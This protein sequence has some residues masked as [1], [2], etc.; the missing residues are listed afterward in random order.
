MKSKVTLI[1]F[2]QVDETGTGP[3]VIVRSEP[4]RIDRGL[5]I[6]EGDRYV[7]DVLL[8]MVNEVVVNAIALPSN[9]VPTMIP[10][11]KT[12]Y[13]RVRD[14]RIVPSSGVQIPRPRA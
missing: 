8:R 7:S 14:D 12:T 10:T 3:P 11:M 6:E 9:I 4:D 13:I 2:A 5:Q 1:T